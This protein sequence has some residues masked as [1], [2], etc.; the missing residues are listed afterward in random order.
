[1]IQRQVRH[2][3]GTF[4]PCIS[5]GREPAHIVSHGAERRAPLQ[6]GRHGTSERHH[7]ECARCDRYTSRCS[8]QSAAAA[9]WNEQHGAAATALPFV[10]RRTA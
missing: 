3:S 5:C 6:F 8:D 10:K 9:E 7:L 1:M 4:A 2:Q